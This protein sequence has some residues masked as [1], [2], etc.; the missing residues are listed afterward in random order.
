MEETTLE[1][2]S[3]RNPHGTLLEKVEEL[4][5][6][7]YIVLHQFPKMERFLLCSEIKTSLNTITRLI[8]T[9]W[10]KYH[11]KTTLTEL[12]IEIEILRVLVRRAWLLQYI[13]SD[14]LRIWNNHINEI[15][16]MT[17]GWIKSIKE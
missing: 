17:G 12:D 16:K 3:R 5:A 13:S 15:G 10:K 7:S 6:Y 9:A 2:S 14:R 4:S 8:V 1:E 11:K